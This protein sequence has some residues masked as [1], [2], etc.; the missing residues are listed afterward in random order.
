MAC[1]ISTEGFQ[2]HSG[3]SCVIVRLFHDPEVLR[4]YQQ[5]LKWISTIDAASGSREV[6]RFVALHSAFKDLDKEKW[7]IHQDNPG[8]TELEA[9]CCRPAAW[10]PTVKRDCNMPV[11][12]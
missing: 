5:N 2:R 4:V 10:L 6:Q 7:F 12:C 11:R 8:V 9:N 1:Q 3:Q